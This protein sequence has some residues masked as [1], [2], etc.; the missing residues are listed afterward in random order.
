MNLFRL[1]PW[2]EKG[3][4]LLAHLILLKWILF[5]LFSGGLFS[6]SLLLVHFLGMAIFGAF[7]I[8]G[9]AYLIKRRHI[10]SLKKHSLSS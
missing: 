10:L 5:V 8:R 1:I 3:F 9:T 6:T 2:M 7:L 4:I